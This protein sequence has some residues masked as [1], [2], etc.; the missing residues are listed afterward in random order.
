MLDILKYFHWV[1]LAVEDFGHDFH[2]ALRDTLLVPEFF[3]VCE[4]LIDSFFLAFLV[5]AQVGFVTDFVCVGEELLLSR[6]G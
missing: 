6:E 4:G 5:F 3:E 1:V 2:V